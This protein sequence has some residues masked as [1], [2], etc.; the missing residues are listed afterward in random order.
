MRERAKP[1]PSRPSYWQLTRIAKAGHRLAFG[2]GSA[3][4]NSVGRVSFNA[5]TK[6]AVLKAL[7]EFALSM[8]P[9]SVPS[10]L[11]GC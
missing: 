2:R 3:A 9:W 1:W 8:T 10:R 5:I 11:A 7:E 4:T 6:V